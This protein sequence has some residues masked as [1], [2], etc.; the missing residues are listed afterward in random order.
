M[1][2][3][4]GKEQKADKPFAC[5]YSELAPKKNFTYA[6]HGFAIVQQV[7]HHGTHTLTD[8]QTSGSK[9]H[10]HSIQ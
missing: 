8:Q 7:H 6:A 2:Y 1:S 5:Y 10:P 4:E 9:Y 3:E